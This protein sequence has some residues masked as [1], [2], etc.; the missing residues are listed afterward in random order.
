MKYSKI[1]DKSV[2]RYPNARILRTLDKQG[3]SAAV[4]GNVVRTFAAA[5]Y[6]DARTIAQQDAD[7]LKRRVWLSLVGSDIELFAPL[8]ARGQR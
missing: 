7:R 8:A 2:A 3:A 4:T 6:D 5:S 1:T